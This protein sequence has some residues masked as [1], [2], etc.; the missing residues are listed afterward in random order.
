MVSVEGMLV[1]EKGS[2]H[3]T[4]KVPAEI[5]PT[6]KVSVPETEKKLKQAMGF[7]EKRQA[8]V[9]NS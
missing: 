8:Q 1:V 9:D 6:E 7:A 2:A 4:E 5:V 3:N